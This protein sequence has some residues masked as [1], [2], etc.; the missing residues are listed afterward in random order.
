MSRL[1]RTWAAWVVLALGRPSAAPL[2]PRPTIA[3]TLRLDP[4]HLDV[5]DVTVELDD[6]PA[7][8]HLAMKVHAEYDARYWRYLD[9]VGVGQT[10]D[11]DRAGVLREDSTLWRVSLPGGHGAVH[12]RVHIQ[13]PRSG[14]RRAWL[15]Y[16]RAD[17][18]LINPPD[19]FLYLPE[20]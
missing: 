12:Y 2:S 18:V 17:G 4:A 14:L 11:D 1:S 8:V 5:A 19:F 7:S 10:A 6:V 15:P 20:V 9:D 13:P 16:A 3:Y